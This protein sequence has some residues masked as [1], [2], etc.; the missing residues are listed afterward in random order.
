MHNFMRPFLIICTLF[1]WTEIIGQV[2]FD[3]NIIKQ[4]DSVYKKLPKESRKELSEISNKQITKIGLAFLT[5]QKTDTLNT[6]NISNLKDVVLIDIDP[7]SHKPIKTKRKKTETKNTSSLVFCFGGLGNDT[8]AIQIG[9]PFFGQTI[10][11][12]VSSNNVSTTYNERMK[13]DAIFKSLYNDT[14]TNNLTISAQTIKFILSDSNF[15]LGKTLYGMA[16]IITSPYFKKDTWDEDEYFE[17][18]HNIKYYFKVRLT[19]KAHNTVN[20]Q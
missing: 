18:Q 17:L 20:M 12:L 11:H 16:E 6:Q 13:H 10:L 7:V 3:T 1:F 15:T 2:T 9:E 14:L 19:E 4:Y 5:L 8:L